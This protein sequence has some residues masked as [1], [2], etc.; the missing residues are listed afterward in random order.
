MHNKNH[1]VFITGKSSKKKILDDD[2]DDNFPYIIF[3]SNISHAQNFILLMEIKYLKTV[4]DCIRL[5]H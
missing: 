3:V 2:D 5:Y 4:D 1:L